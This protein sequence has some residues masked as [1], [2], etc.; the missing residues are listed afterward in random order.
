M[1]VIPPTVCP[2]GPGACAIAIGVDIGE[3][4]IGYGLIK[5]LEDLFGGGP[6]F[7]GSLK[8]RPPSN[9]GW[10]GNFG[11][12]LGIPTSIPRGNLG[13]GRSGYLTG[14]EKHGRISTSMVMAVVAQAIHTSILGTGIRRPLAYQAVGLSHI[15]FRGRSL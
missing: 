14:Q 4:A 11:E 6:S 12:S 8:P 9:G 7:H 5:G 2:A 10:D 1:P 15:G 3:L 13:I